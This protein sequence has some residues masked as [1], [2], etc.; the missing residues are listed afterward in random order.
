[1]KA[2]QQQDHLNFCISICSSFLLHSSI[3]SGTSPGEVPLKYNLAGKTVDTVVPMP[4]AQQTLTDASI[5]A[6]DGTTIL[7][8]TK[9]MAEP[10]EIEISPTDN[11]MLW[12][13]GS[14]STLAFHAARDSF[15][16]NLSEGTTSSIPTVTPPSND[17]C[18]PLDPNPDSF[19]DGTFPSSPWSVSGEDGVWSVTTDK[20]FDGTTS[21]KSPTLEGSGAVSSTS[22]A[23]LI[24]CK[25]NFPGGVMRLQAYASVQPPTDIFIVY[26]DG[27]AAAQLV[28]VNEWTELA[29]GLEPG[30]HVVNFS[31]QYNPFEVA[32]LPP[33]PPTREGKYLVFLCVGHIKSLSTC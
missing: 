6:E 26:I 33:S 20:S 13:Y 24:I 8:F 30:P 32:D 15:T 17:D 9:I 18:V 5:T 10:D 14:D 19:E 31:Y 22:N 12:A 11:T 4:D 21:L 2:H 29:L 16:I 27:E 3:N 23:T 28:D 1:M 25:E 7:R